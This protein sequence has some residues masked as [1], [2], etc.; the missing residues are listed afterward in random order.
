MRRR[1]RRIA[2]LPPRPFF[3]EDGM[4]RRAALAVCDRLVWTALGL[5]LGALATT[6]AHAQSQAAA[7]GQPPAPAQQAQGAPPARVFT[8]D[9]C[10]VLNFIKPDKTKD[11][12]AIVAKV[13]EALTAS[14]KPE[15][16]EQAK[17]W[18]VFKAAEPA[19]GGAALYVF[20]VDPP[21]KNADYTVT[22]LLAEALTPGEMTTVSKQYVDSYASGQNF[23]NLALV[24]DFGK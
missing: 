24:S 14:A 11:F 19:A 10:L 15:R 6:L 16:N 5:I 23:V 22:T 17:S 21:L 20:I 12:E 4:I 8:S 13:K 1:D 2:S 9:V 7:A 3:Q 18:R